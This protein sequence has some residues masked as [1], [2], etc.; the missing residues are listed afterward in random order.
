[1]LCV[2]MIYVQCH[3]VIFVNIVLIIYNRND[4]IFLLQDETSAKKF[5][6]I[7]EAYEVLGNVKLK[8]MYDR[9]KINVW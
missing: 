8:K 4:M 5:R 3:Y 6:A 9:G 1:M 2:I 7:T